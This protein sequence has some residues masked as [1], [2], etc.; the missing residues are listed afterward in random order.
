MTLRYVYFILL[1]VCLAVV[2]Y[3]VTRTNRCYCQ[4]RQ[5][6]LNL[7]QECIYSFIRAEVLCTSG[8]LQCS[9]FLNGFHLL[10]GRPKLLCHLSHT[11]TLTYLA[12]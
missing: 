7:L 8:P 12:Y 5:R 3:D 6:E 9:E 1:F 11:S 10:V 4:G 2:T